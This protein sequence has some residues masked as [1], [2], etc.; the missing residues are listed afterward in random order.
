MGISPTAEIVSQLHGGHGLLQA[1]QR[2]LYGAG[3]AYRLHGRGDVLQPRAGGQDDRSLVALH[4]PSVY[5]FDQT[6]IS[7]GGCGL[8]EEACIVD[9]RNGI[10]AIQVKTNRLPRKQQGTPA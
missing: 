4:Q 7:C 6:G 5:C 9:D 2:W 3:L 10:R 1:F 8:C